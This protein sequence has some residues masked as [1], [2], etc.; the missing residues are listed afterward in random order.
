M[1]S[2]SGRSSSSKPTDEACRRWAHVPRERPHQGDARAPARGVGRMGRRRG[3]RHRG[4][5]ARRAAWN[6]VRALGGRPGRA[7]ALRARRRGGPAGPVRVRA[8]GPGP[9]RLGALRDGDARGRDRVRGARGTRAS[10]TTRSSSRPERR[11]PSRSSAT[12]GRRSTRT[13][14]VLRPRSLR[15]LRVADRGVLASASWR[16]RRHSRSSRELSSQIERAVVLRADGSVL[17]STGD[18]P[19]APKRSRGALSSSSR[20]PSSC[21]RRRPR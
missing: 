9:G 7:A 8:R 4:R 10:G 5:R 1:R 20:R 3:L 21:A 13:A 16:R 18:D 14:R 19:A 17:A 12:R 15:P 11:G 6:R 2:R